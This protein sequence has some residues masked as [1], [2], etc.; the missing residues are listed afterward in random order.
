[1]H[2]QTSSRTTNP[3]LI[4]AIGLGA[5]IFDG[6]DLI[7]FGSIVP[8]LLAHP[9]WGLTPASVGVLGSYALMGMLVGALICGPL[10]D[11]FGRKT[12]FVTCLAWYSVLALVSAFSPTPEFFGMVRFLAGLGFGGIGPVVVALVMEAVPAGRRNLM[13]TVVLCGLPIGGV[14]AALAALTLKPMI[15]FRGLLAFGGIALVTIVPM[16]IK[17]LPETQGRVVRQRTGWG[18]IAADVSRAP[19]AL[20]VFS[21]LMFTGFFLVFGL[22]TWLPKLMTNAGYDLGSALGFLLVLNLGAVI[23]GLVGSRIADKHHPK[24]A[25]WLA[26]AVASVSVMALGMKSPVIILYALVFIAGAAAIGAQ[27]MTYNYSAAWFPQDIRGT[28]L[29]L[30][31]G[32]GRLGA[33]LGPIIG[34]LILDEGLGLGWSFGVF[35]FAAVVATIACVV[36]PRPVGK[37]AGPSDE[38]ATTPSLARQ[39]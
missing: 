20:A 33:I 11:R 8:D 12:V 36:L 24:T 29:G 16:A 5:I 32:V 13:S 3:W 21:I 39:H 1:M 9:G 28:A 37:L 25:T 2:A 30:T 27:M 4:V 6:Y 15:G 22:N 31:S 26:F 34:G 7:V 17:W 10:A 18:K 19:F 35:T 14:L 23:G 38:T